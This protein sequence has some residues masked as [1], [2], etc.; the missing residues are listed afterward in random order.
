MPELARPSWDT[1]W[2][3]MAE[4]IGAR[5]KCCR[6]QVGCVIVS[7]NQEL[8]GGGYN[9]PPAKYPAEGSCALWCPR[10]RGEGGDGNVYDNC[11]SSHAEANCI[12]RCDYERVK[13]ATAYV[14]RSCCFTCAKLLS[15]AK[16]ARVVHRVT[17]SDLHRDPEGVEEFFRKC[18]VVVERWND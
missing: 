9:G 14:T 5:S 7:E 18:G 13:G 1:V 10:G 17:D 15:A 4:A 11:P 8:I 3:T 12:V 2:F 16:V 6:A